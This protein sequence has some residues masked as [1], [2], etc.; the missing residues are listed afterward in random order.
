MK[1]ILNVQWGTGKVVPLERESI[2][3]EIHCNLLPGQR[4]ALVSP[5]DWK[6]TPGKKR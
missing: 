5:S 1:E 4:R 3:G 6:Y 2:E